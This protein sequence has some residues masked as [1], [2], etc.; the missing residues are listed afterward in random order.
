[1]KQQEYIN[2]VTDLLANYRNKIFRK[3]LSSEY[4]QS[5][6]LKE[7]KLYDISIK[8]SLKCIIR[9][10]IIKA[11]LEQK[12]AY[13]SKQ[14][15]EQ[16]L[17]CSDNCN[18]IYILNKIPIESWLSKYVNNI[19]C[20][21]YDNL[22]CYTITPILH[23]VIGSL[24][25][26]SQDKKIRKLYGQYFTEKKYIDLI[27]DRI[28]IDTNTKVLE[29]AVGGGS[30][31]SE[32]YRRIISS[33]DGCIP[34]EIY[35]K[36]LY[37]LDIDEFCV[38]LSLIN[39]AFQTHNITNMNY[40]IINSDF[41]DYDFSQKFDVIIGNPPYNAK[42]DRKIKEKMKNKYP[43]IT[44]GDPE[45]PG[46]YNTA[47]LFLRKSIDLLNQNGY[48]GFILPN[49]ILR[50]H[51]YKKLRDFI[52]ENCT[53]ESIINIGQAFNDVGLEM[54]IIILK[55]KKSSS[56]DNI[57]IVTTIENNRFTSHKLNHLYLSKW[58]I[59]PIYLD[60]HLGY[61]ADKIAKNT[62][63]LED[64]CL[65][66]RGISISSKSKLFINNPFL[67]DGNYVPVLRG[68][69][70]GRYCIK[71]PQLFVEKSSKIFDSKMELFKQEKILVQNVAKRIVATYDKYKFVALDTIN[72]LILKDKYKDRYDYRYLL[73]IINSELMEFYFQN[74]INNRSKLTIHMDKPYLG[75]IPIKVPDNE[76]K[77][78]SQVD[79]ILQLNEILNIYDP[80]NILNTSF[81][82]QQE[83]EEIF[84][85][86]SYKRKII[87]E[88]IHLEY[89]NLDNMIYEIYEI[90]KNDIKYIKKNLGV[91]SIRQ[92]SFNTQVKS[93]LDKYENFIDKKKANLL[94]SIL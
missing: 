61:I 43:D 51:S 71:H 67:E 53:V 42:L 59:F 85:N 76:S 65:M 2:Q 50:V 4:I 58:N 45:T 11:W 66:P 79:K 80:I 86:F 92:F 29:P 57:E 44:I 5:K 64:I 84:H 88:Q 23:Y 81:G 73:A 26:K 3:I 28:P 68:Q 13:L 15:I 19:I 48:L 69:D 62:I 14:D 31:I 38:T 82:S 94:K 32:A 78:I 10:I 6:K 20:E 40:N 77:I 33:S 56:S 63:L 91:N 16:L 24:Y 8:L 60:N 93:L 89:N 9:V 55:K 27:L 47:A 74:T 12:N 52:L 75:R 25:E 70:I 7:K 46:T 72:L 34:K 1:M 22:D 35:H 83:L 36:N 39:M 18:D 17:L 37:G 54:I 87:E 90:D 21:L 30:F 49:S 41:L